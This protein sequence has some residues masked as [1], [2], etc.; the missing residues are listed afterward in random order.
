M[1]WHVLSVLNPDDKL[2]ASSGV[3]SL[4]VINF[5][6]ADDDAELRQVMAQTLHLTPGLKLTRDFASAE[7]L[8]QALKSESAPHVVVLDLKMGGLSG[9]DAIAPIKQLAPQ[10]QIIIFT[11]FHDGAARR[12]ALA[13]GAADFVLKRNGVGSV[14]GT[15]KKLFQVD[16]PQLPPPGHGFIAALPP[17]NP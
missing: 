4:G 2:A 10:T 8:L 3:L 16:L 12:K 13:A 6:L 9:V 1:T 7:D 14:V 11:T 15:I 17:A 5:W